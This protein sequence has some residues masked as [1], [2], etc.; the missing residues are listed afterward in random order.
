M[1]MSVSYSALESG[2]SAKKAVWSVVL[3]LCL[4]SFTV[5]AQE[6]KYEY[7]V[8]VGIGSYLG[9]ANPSIPFTP[10]GAEVAAS[11][12]YNANFR[13]AFSA[14]VGYVLL[15]FNTMVTENAFPVQS[16]DKHKG[17]SH[18]LHVQLLAEYNFVH[19]SD[20]FR[21]LNTRRL[22]PFISGGIDLGVAPFAETFVFAPGLTLGVGMK[23]KIQNRLNL[24]VN[25]QG[26]HYFSDALD[27][28]SNDLGWLDNP[29]RIP[30]Q[31][32]KGGDGRM[33]L[34]VGL[35]YEFGMRRSTCQ[36]NSN[37]FAK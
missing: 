31:F 17:V 25:L 21:Y 7:G 16:G 6:Y 29:Y 32:V 3:L 30:H 20:K 13:S 19:Y 4:G 35:T 5:Q 26:F 37:T 33:A 18:L 8:Q 23:Y 2:S 15:P 28:P 36:N 9:D 12:R 24:V 22:A 27:T 10:L 11:W 1:L 34:T 14:H